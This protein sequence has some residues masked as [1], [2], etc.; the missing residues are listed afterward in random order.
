MLFF[1]L[2]ILDSCCPVL[3]DL[4]YFHWF[5]KVEGDGGV[6]FLLSGANGVEVTISTLVRP[7]MPFSHTGHRHGDRDKGLAIRACGLPWR[8]TVESKRNLC[9]DTDGKCTI[10]KEQQKSP[11]HI[12]LPGDWTVAKGDHG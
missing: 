8:R 3:V 10:S 11:Q 12:E 4:S 2:S 5:A 7:L 1:N 6:R 9:E